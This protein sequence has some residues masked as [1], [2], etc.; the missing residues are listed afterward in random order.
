[1]TG[2]RKNRAKARLSHGDAVLPGLAIEAALCGPAKMD[3]AIDLGLD[4]NRPI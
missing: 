1:M 4:S 3:E 2:I